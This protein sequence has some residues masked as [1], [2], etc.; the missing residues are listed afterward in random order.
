M[1]IYAPSAFAAI[2]FAAGNAKLTRPAAVVRNHAVDL[3][4]CPAEQREQMAKTIRQSWLAEQDVEV[5]PINAILEEQREFVARFKQASLH[6]LTAARRV[7]HSPWHSGFCTPSK[8]I[9]GTAWPRAQSGR[10]RSS[11]HPKRTAARLPDQ[12]IL[13]AV[14]TALPIAFS[15]AV[16]GL[17]PRTV[18]RLHPNCRGR[19]STR[20]VDGVDVQRTYLVA[21]AVN[22]Y[23]AA[24]GLRALI[25]GPLSLAGFVKGHRFFGE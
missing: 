3:T 25:R 2:D 6:V 19:A 15:V 20:F 7:M 21:I 16:H 10:W 18:T 17:R 12:P 22:G 5:Q 4:D 13:A 11:P 14:R 24:N 23:V 9:G 1:R 8:A